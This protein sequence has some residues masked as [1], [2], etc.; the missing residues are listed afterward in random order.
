M[1]QDLNKIAGGS[2]GLRTTSALYKII[3]ET[4]DFISV[5]QNIADTIP[6]ELKFALGAVAILDETENSLKIVAVS[7][8]PEADK[9]AK[10]VPTPLNQIE[11]SVENPTNLMA[12]AIREKKSFITGDLYNVLGPSLTLEEAK[13]I[14]EISQIKTTL[15]FPIVSKGRAT[16]VFVTSTREV[17]QELSP[18]EL[19]II[20]IFAEGASVAVEHALLYKNLQKVTDE[21]SVANEKLKE[22]DKLKD[23]FLS[24][25]SHELRTP[26]NAIKGYIWMVLNGKTGEIKDPKMKEYLSRTYLS[27]ERLI[28]LVNDMLDV[29]RIEG[30]RIELKPVSFD[31]VVLA[32]ETLLELQPKAQERQ[33]S[34]DL[35]DAQTAKVTA[36]PDKIHQVLTNILGNALKFTPA[37]GK[38]TLSFR[39]ADGFVEASVADTGPGISEGDQAKLFQ[40]FSRLDNAPPATTTVPSTGLGLYISK[41]IVEL[42]GG[43]IGVNSTLGKGST[44]SFTL[45]TTESTS[46]VG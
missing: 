11:I 39:Q 12:K 25:A 10:A 16:G 8:T 23:E 27:T 42:S 2:K 4:L 20:R 9:I 34:L 41:K 3:L 33:I 37:T 1:N 32:K 13:G 24:I 22:L 5:I 35:I 45:P 38:V 18:Y 7:K 28:N 21:L 29:S 15:V 30:G 17:Q 31:L 19:E 14:Q 43:K 36:D 46:E 26:M 6:F 44:F 40:K